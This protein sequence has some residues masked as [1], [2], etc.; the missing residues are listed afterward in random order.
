MLETRGIVVARRARC[1]E[2][3]AREVTSYLKLSLLVPALKRCSVAGCKCAKLSLALRRTTRTRN[4][5]P[6]HVKHLSMRA[7]DSLL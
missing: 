4:D 1:G 2:V 3:E 7:T 5:A 6:A